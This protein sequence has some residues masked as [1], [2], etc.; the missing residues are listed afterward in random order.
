M[1]CF[2]ITTVFACLLQSEIAEGCLDATNPAQAIE[3][4]K[5]ILE[6]ARQRDA[7]VIYGH[8]PQQWNE[9]IKAPARYL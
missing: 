3:S 6:L 4:G 9:L 7:L 2:C 5:R 1:V 8:G